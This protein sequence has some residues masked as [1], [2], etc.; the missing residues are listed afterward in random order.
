MSEYFEPHLGIDV[1]VATSPVF[2]DKRE[3]IGS[4]H[5]V[6]D[7]TKRKLM[8]EQLITQGRLASIGQL[9]AGIAHEMNNPLTSVVGF[10]ELLL[11]RTDLP[12]DAKEDLKLVNE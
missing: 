9:A 11:E 12:A 4:V 3:M 7:V 6:R 10:S 2:N 8:E 5:V 1:E